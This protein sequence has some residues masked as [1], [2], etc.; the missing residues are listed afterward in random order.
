M[1]TPNFLTIHLIS[2]SVAFIA[3]CFL[4]FSFSL[5]LYPIMATND[6][7]SNSLTTFQDLINE[8]SQI[9]STSNS[10]LDVGSQNS[11]VNNNGSSLV[12]PNSTSKNLISTEEYDKIKNCSPDTDKKP[13]SIEYLTF[14]NC[15]HVKSSSSSPTAADNDDDNNNQL[16]ANKNLLCRDR[17]KPVYTSLQVMVYVLPI[18]DFNGTISGP[19]MWVTEVDLGK[20]QRNNS[21][22][23]NHTH[24]LHLHSIA[25][26]RMDGIDGPGGFIKPGQNL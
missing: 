18:M 11:L 13:S 2:L 21:K 26:Q 6:I 19:T 16:T 9:N 4:S 25:S 24:S 23:N 5:S 20:N 7:N 12:T 1:Q 3:V 22:E 15:G 14:F 8:N 17:G 10:L